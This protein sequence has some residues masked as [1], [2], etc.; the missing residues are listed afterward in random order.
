MARHG[1]GKSS[2]DPTHRGFALGRRLRR[3]RMAKQ[4][5]QERLAAELGV[6]QGMLSRW[7][8]GVHEPSPQAR[9]RIEKI[10]ERHQDAGVDST[11]R[12]LI[13]GAPFPVHLVCED[14]FALLAVSPVREA[15]WR[16]EA[17]ALYGVSLRSFATPEIIERERQL[18]DSG[19]FEGRGSGPIRFITSG[20]DDPD[21]P[22]L[23]STVVWERVGIGDGRVGLLVTNEAL[24]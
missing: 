1:C 22:I 14:T 10:L 18:R 9:A 8:S 6:S 24:F 5:K 16:I 20:N 23:P 19:W 11:L 15:E 17:A 12:R 3:F 21:V 2:V 7:E 13:E 4:I